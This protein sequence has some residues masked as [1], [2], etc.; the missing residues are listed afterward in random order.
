[1]AVELLTLSDVI[2]DKVATPKVNSK[3]ENNG[4]LRHAE[5]IVT[6]TGTTTTNGSTYLAVRLPAN[7]VLKYGSIQGQGSIDLPN[8]DVGVRQVASPNTLDDDAFAAALD[9]DDTG[10]HVFIGALG[11]QDTT[12]QLWEWADPAG[13]VF[14]GVNPGGEFDI[15]LSLDADAV[16]AGSCRVIVQYVVD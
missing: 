10:D 15:H 5:A 12:K 3:P 4:T 9:I 1:M 11:S 16:A 6:T 2:A 14:N 7:A 13:T 8:V